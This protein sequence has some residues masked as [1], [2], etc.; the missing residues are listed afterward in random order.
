MELILA[1]ASPR[2][3]EL[4]GMTGISFRAQ[5]AEVTEPAPGGD[6]PQV[7]VQKLAEL[8]ASAVSS[9]NPDDFVLGADTIVYVDGTI[10]GKPHTPQNASE[11]LHLLSGRTHTVYT[12][13]ALIG[14]GTKDIRYDAT[15]VTFSAMSDDEIDWYVSTGDPLDKAGAY[16]VQGLAA[17]FV[18]RIEGNYFNV[19]GLPIPLMYEMLKKAGFLYAGTCPVHE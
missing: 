8:K 9:L 10:L 15:N 18:K 2:R 17:P 13:L 3:K 5:T 6:A 1:S 11:Y 7:Y 14:P 12:G 4:L 19:V 16:G